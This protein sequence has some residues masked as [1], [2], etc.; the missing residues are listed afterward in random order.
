MAKGV[1]KGFNDSMPDIGQNF[2][3]ILPHD[4]GTLIPLHHSLGHFG[5]LQPCL[6]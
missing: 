3:P 5:R 2:S 1:S 6:G 4:W